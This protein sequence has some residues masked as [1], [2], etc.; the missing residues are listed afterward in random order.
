MVTQIREL[1]LIRQS[2]SRKA[3]VRV[4][5]IPILMGLLVATLVASLAVGAVSIP[6]GRVVDVLLHPAAPDVD[7][8][9]ATIIWDMRFG[10]VLLAA[11]IGAGLA[12]AGA[13]LQGLFR[14]P[15]ADPFVVGASGGAALGATLAIIAG[16]Q[17]GAAGF[18]PVPLA[19]F[20]GAMLAVVLVYGIAEMGGTTPA[21]ALLLAGAALSTFLGAVVALLLMLSDQNLYAVFVWLLG[22]LSGRSWPHLRASMPYMIIGIGTLW[23][24][25]RPLD[26]LAFGD[27]T[28]QSLG[29]PLRWAR[30]AIVAAASLATAAAVAA[31]GTIGF[32]G[33]IAPHAARLLIG[34]G[35]ARLIPA[36]ALVG[37]LLLLLA[38]DLA[39]TVMAP[40][41]LPVGIV[42][43]ML[44]GPFFLYL[45]KTRQ[46]Q[47]GA[48]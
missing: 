36:S 44:G 4:A 33:L 46:R 23:L 2:L 17:W 41:E 30:G 18:G 34:T 31:G 7:P 47:L 11:L 3:H 1:S 45:L 20:G 40:L 10:R 28:A 35:H 6:V 8:M 5:L 14:N 27:E 25:A 16:L 12:A 24:L 48:P 32:V 38:D 15:L 26:A 42:T 37:A 19:A 21:I 39:R 29:L 13:A 22:G 9:E 43:A